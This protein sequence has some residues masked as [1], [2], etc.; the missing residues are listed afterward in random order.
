VFELRVCFD[1]DRT[2]RRED[3]ERSGLIDEGFLCGIGPDVFFERRCPEPLEVVQQIFRLVFA[4]DDVSIVARVNSWLM[5]VVPYSSGA[6]QRDR[7]YARPQQESTGSSLEHL[8]CRRLYIEGLAL[9]W[10]DDATD[11]SVQRVG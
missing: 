1:A 2:Q 10:Q 7:R 3:G 11:V 8:R 4:V 9:N 6:S 5:R